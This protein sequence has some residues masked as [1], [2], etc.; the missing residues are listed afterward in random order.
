MLEKSKIIIAE[1]EDK[2]LQ[3]TALEATL[4]DMNIEGQDE[5]EYRKAMV[6]NISDETINVI[7]DNSSSVPANKYHLRTSHR[8][9]V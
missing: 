9:K 4:S 8:L 3:I 1:N 5:D 7:G 6:T 2:T